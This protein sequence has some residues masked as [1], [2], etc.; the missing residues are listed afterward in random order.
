[1]TFFGWRNI[2]WQHWRNYLILACRLPYIRSHVGHILEVIIE[3]WPLVL[4]LNGRDW[5]QFFDQTYSSFVL[6]Q[7]LFLEV[8]FTYKN[9]FKK[10]SQGFSIDEYQS[11]SFQRSITWNW[12]LLQFSREYT[13]H[14]LYISTNENWFLFS[15]KP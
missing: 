9:R 14:K 4:R 15:T 5:L 2:G 11:F 8:E 12:C 13:E 6:L 10:Y 1:M 7:I 3:D